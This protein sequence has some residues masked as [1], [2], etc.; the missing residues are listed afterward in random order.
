MKEQNVKDYPSLI[1]QSGG[2]VVS[3][4]TID[5]ETYINNR[6]ALKR[7]DDEIE[8]MKKDISEIKELLKK[9]AKNNG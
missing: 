1:K 8:K 9:L 7:K 3:S 6:K 5:Y 2:G 4:S